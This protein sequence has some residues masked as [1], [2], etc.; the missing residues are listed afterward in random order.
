MLRLIKISFFFPASI[1]IA[2]A[3]I[4]HL[5]SAFNYV[6]LPLHPPSPLYSL[7]YLAEAI[8]HLFQ[9]LSQTIL[10]LHNICHSPTQNI[11]SHSYLC[12]VIMSASISQSSYCFLPLCPSC[13]KKLP[14]NSHTEF[15]SPV[16]HP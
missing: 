13:S 2:A 3:E 6:T 11:D 12:T 5:T 10:S 1:Q 8:C 9:D 4:I 7:P 15:L 14:I 16:S